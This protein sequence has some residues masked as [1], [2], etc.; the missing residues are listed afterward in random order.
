[1]AYYHGLTPTMLCKE[2]VR[3]AS[4]LT[5]QMKLGAPFHADGVFPTCTLA[6]DSLEGFSQAYLAPLVSQ[7]VK[8]RSKPWLQLMEMPSNAQGAR[9]QWGGVACRLL[10][11]NDAFSPHH[12]TRIHVDFEFPAI[13]CEVPLYH[14][15]GEQAEAASR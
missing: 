14:W 12:G 11:I 6:I 10:M 13:S 2:I 8:Q 15:L 9:E 4:G 1:M 3:L 7:A 5:W